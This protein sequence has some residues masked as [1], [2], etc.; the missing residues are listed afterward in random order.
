MNEARWILPYF[1]S[2][3]LMLDYEALQPSPFPWIAGQM[4][5]SGVSSSEICMAYLWDALATEQ[6]IDKVSAECLIG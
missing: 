6:G 3:D 4:A 1:E 2:V 5:S